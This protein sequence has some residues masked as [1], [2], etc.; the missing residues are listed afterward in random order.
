MKRGPGWVQREQQAGK[1]R[2]A[3]GRLLALGSGSEVLL[4][5]GILASG[6]RICLVSSFPCSYEWTLNIKNFIN[7]QV[8]N[9]FFTLPHWAVG[10]RIWINSIRGIPEVPN[11]ATPM[12]Q[13]FW[14]HSQKSQFENILWTLEASWLPL[15]PSQRLQ[16]VLVPHQQ[17][18]WR[19]TTGFFS[20]CPWIL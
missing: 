5:F 4:T 2:Q 12:L 1:W 19:V 16:N 14:L 10:M 7:V 17:M 11:V 18:Q 15:Y 3:P 20:F 13:N 6:I 9:S 8:C